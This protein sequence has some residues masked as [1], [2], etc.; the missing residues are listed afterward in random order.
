MRTFIAL[1]LAFAAGAYADA[2]TPFYSGSYGLVTLGAVGGVSGYGAIHFEQG[3]SSVLLLGIND[4]SAAGAIEAVNVTR[5]AGGHITGFGSATQLSTAPFIDAGMDYISDGDLLF[6]QFG[7]TGIGEIKPGGSSPATF[8]SSP[9]GG[10]GG[11]IGLVPS[12]VPGAGNLVAASYSNNKLCTTTATPDGGGT[13]TL[14]ACSNS[15]SISNPTGI[16]WVP[17]GAPVFPSAEILINRG[18]TTY[19]YAVDANGLPTGA[20]TAFFTT[21]FS[22]MGAAFDPV[23]G[24]LLLTTTSSDR[25]YEIQG[26]PDPP[27]TPEPGTFAL[28]PATLAVIW[29]GRRFRRTG[30]GL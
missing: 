1:F 26:F 6:V 20:G 23:T 15:V 22:L 7:G 10:S 17:A 27:P 14:S 8:V 24:D 9:G 25:I 2:I 30:P 11:A 4:D 18:S 16:A 29:V 19:A 3:N 13:D 5:G 12:G 21:A 28:V